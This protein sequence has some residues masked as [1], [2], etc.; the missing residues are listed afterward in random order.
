MSIIIVKLPKGDLRYLEFPNVQNEKMTTDLLLGTLTQSLNVKPP[1][2]LFHSLLN[3]LVLLTS[4]QDLRTMFFLQSQLT[5][6]YPLVVVKNETE[7]DPTAPGI[8]SSILRSRL[9]TPEKRKR[10]SKEANLISI[11]SE[12]EAESEEETDTMVS[13][14]PIFHQLRQKLRGIYARYVDSA[15]IF[16]QIGQGVLD[17]QMT[18]NISLLRCDFCI[19]CCYLF[20]VNVYF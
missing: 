16:L 7:Y 1:V 2:Q 5:F 11:E 15:I 20:M 6:K 19:C 4:N 14:S 18:P 8:C 10:T 3:E 9:A 12:P 13:T 17:F